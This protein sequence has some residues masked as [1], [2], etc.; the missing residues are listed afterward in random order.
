MRPT[1]SPAF[2]SKLVL[3]A[4]CLVVLVLTSVFSARVALA[5]WDSWTQPQVIF[6]YPLSGGSDLDGWVAWRFETT[7][8][9][10]QVYGLNQASESLDEIYVYTAAQDRCSPTGSWSLYAYED[11]LKYNAQ[12]A[13]T[14]HLTTPPTGTS[15]GQY[16]N[17]SSYHDYRW[18]VETWG[19]DPPPNWQ[20]TW[21]AVVN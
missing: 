21:Y 7:S 19:V 20:W 13:Y 8:L 18:Y 10:A 3:A 14:D 6:N 9:L 4:A 2:G 16:Q 15:V 1:A 5:Y 17:C 12:V 11:D